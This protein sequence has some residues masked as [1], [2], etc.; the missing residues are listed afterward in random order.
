MDVPVNG[1]TRT[2][3]HGAIPRGKRQTR[4]SELLE[5]LERGSIIAWLAQTKVDLIDVWRNRQ[6]HIL[7]AGSTE[8]CA[9]TSG[10]VSSH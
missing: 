6:G 5:D 10:R 8:R 4:A 2:I 1:G 7:Q 3:L 9:P